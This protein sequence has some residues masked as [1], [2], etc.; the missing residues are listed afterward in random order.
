MNILF[1]INIIVS[2][3]FINNKNII[4]PFKRVTFEKY[5]GTKTINDF[6]SYDIYTDIYMGTPPQ[7]VTHFINPQENVYQLKRHEFYYNIKKFNDSVTQIQK[8][9]F[10]LFY[11]ENSSSYHKNGYYS[12]NYIFNTYNKDETIEV[13]DLKFTIYLTR[14]RFKEFTGR[15]GL[16]S[17]YQSEYDCLLSKELTSFP[18]QLKNKEIID[19]SVFSFIYDNNDD[20]FDNRIKNGKLIIGEYSYKYNPNININ[21]EEKIYSYSATSWSILI[22]QIKFTYN[23]ETYIEEEMEFKFNFFTKF[24]KGSIKYN[25]NIEKIFF[26]DLIQQ[27]LC[28]KELISEN[29]YSNEYEIYY[30]NNT[31]YVNDK[32]K[33]FPNLYFIQK[34]KGLIFSFTY[35]D[36]FKIFNDKIYFMIIFPY[37]PHLSKSFNWDIGEIFLSKFIAN[38]NIDS[39][40]ISFFKNQINEANN[41]I[42]NDNGKDTVNRND[43]NN[44]SKYFKKIN[45]TIKYIIEVII[46]IIIIFCIYLLYRKYIKCRKIKANDLEESNYVY[47]PDE[48]ARKSKLIKENEI[49]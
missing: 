3:Y 23:N 11:P 24:I 10:S 49:N 13:K 7:K 36:L 15:I 48:K 8:E 46:G 38:F 37:N 47:A 20:I 45:S 44:G 43:Y 42:I 28:K 33:N 12:E 25:K 30:C 21:E 5:T 14:T 19:E 16:F 17:I 1:L 9:L 41:Y 29:R 18:L 35:K 22:N 2:I 27:N 40:T 39:K 32:I 26:D 4:L 6:I 34:N 31:I